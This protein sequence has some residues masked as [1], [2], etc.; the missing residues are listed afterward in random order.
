MN[1]LL[2]HTL[3]CQFYTLHLLSLYLLI[4]F[5]IYK[6]RIIAYAILVIIHTFLT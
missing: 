4:A 1:S 6:K 5:G 3:K 2:L